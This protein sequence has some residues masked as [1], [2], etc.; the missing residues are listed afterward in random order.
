[1]H[2]FCSGFVDFGLMEH[3]VLSQKKKKPYANLGD[4]SINHSC[5]QHANNYCVCFVHALRSLLHVIDG[6]NNQTLGKDWTGVCRYKTAYKTGI[7]STCPGL[8]NR[9]DFS[10]PFV[11]MGVE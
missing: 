7:P 6:Y 10:I 5:E 3:F 11:R 9:H 2:H 4:E 8:D 1:M